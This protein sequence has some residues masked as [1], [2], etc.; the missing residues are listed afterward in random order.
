MA[1]VEEERIGGVTIVTRAVGTVQEG[2]R[3]LVWEQKP[4]QGLETEFELGTEVGT[5]CHGYCVPC[6]YCCCLLKS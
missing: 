6:S 2:A 5:A 1:G 3:V 4:L